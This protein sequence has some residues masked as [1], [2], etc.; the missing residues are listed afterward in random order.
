MQRAKEEWHTLEVEI[1][2]IPD[3]DEC[4]ERVNTFYVSLPW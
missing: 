2:E 1:G 3:F 4:F